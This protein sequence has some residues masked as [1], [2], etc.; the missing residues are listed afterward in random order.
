[1][2][3]RHYVY[4]ITNIKTDTHYIGV[5]FCDIDPKDDIGIKLKKSQN[6]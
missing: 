1:M 5:R 6:D 3:S 4:N 2:R